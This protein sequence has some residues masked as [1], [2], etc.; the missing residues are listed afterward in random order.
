MRVLSLAVCITL[1]AAGAALSAPKIDVNPPLFDFGVVTEGVIV[2]RSFVV[3]N[4]GDAPLTIRAIRATCGCTATTDLAGTALAP[5][6]SVALAVRVDTSGFSGAIAKDVRISSN[7]PATPEAVLWML[8][9]VT[10]LPPYQITPGDVRYLLYVLVDIR[11]SDAYAAGHLLGAIHVPSDDLPTALDPL[12]RNAFVILYDDFGPDAAT[13]A[14]HLQ[15]AGYADAWTLAGGLAAWVGAFGDTLLSESAATPSPAVTTLAA[16]QSLT[17]GDLLKY[18]YLLL[19]ARSAEAYAAGH[20]IGALPFPTDGTPD[21]LTRVPKEVL[22]VVYDEEGETAD[23]VALSLQDAG[24]AA[25]SLAG[26]FA[27][28]VEAFGT[29]FVWIPS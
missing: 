23:D 16:S 10:P 13:A 14:R 11:S 19:D 2:A 1:A 9:T 7:D 12:P 24:F 6:E 27:G 22:L 29:A 15:E 3:T 4:I 20:L 26:G 28:W 17:A 21:W 8:G 5:G 18:S 25:R